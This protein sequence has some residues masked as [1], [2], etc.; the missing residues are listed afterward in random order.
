[1]ESGGKWFEIPYKWCK[2]VD[3]LITLLITLSQKV[4]QEEG[5]S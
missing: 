4:L 5:V 3:K 1:M 2:V